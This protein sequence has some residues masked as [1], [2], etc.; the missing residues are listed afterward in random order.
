M[1][2]R[3]YSCFQGALTCTERTLT[4]TTDPLCSLI[5][6]PQSPCLTL[7]ISVSHSSQHYLPNTWH[8]AKDFFSVQ[9]ESMFTPVLL[10]NR[11]F[12]QSACKYR[13]LPITLTESVSGP[14]YA[15]FKSRREEWRRMEGGWMGRMNGEDEGGGWTGRMNGEDEWGGWM[16][17]VSVRKEL[18]TADRTITKDKITRER[19]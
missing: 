6:P 19:G 12:R 13:R 8:T 4:C 10:Y 3:L 7:Y 14:Q 1:Y 16:G 17:N 11:F 9:E 18:S 15:G 2:Q 5:Q